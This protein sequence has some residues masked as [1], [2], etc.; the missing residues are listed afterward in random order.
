MSQALHIVTL[1]FSLIAMLFHF[2]LYLET[3]GILKKCESA[4]WVF[5]NILWEH[6]TVPAVRKT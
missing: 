4:D 3:S 6:L 2:Q 5:L 1:G